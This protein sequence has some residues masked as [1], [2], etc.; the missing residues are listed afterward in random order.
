VTDKQKS[1]QQNSRKQGS[2]KQNP[3]LSPLEIV[4][5][6]EAHPAAV[7]F[8]WLGSKKTQRNFIYIPLVGMIVFSILGFFYPVSKPAPWDFG[9]S[10]TVIGFVGYS[11]VVL[12]AWPL[13]R[14]LSR[15][16]NY[17]GE[18]DSVEEGEDA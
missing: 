1:D 12:S 8:L 4:E 17:Y 18:D 10:Y 6:A 9:F 16:E 13:F 15:P 7:P 3:V 11:F 14:L 2:G 5:R